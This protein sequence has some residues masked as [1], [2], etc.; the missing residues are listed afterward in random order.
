MVLL[1]KPGW[2]GASEVSPECTV[3]VFEGASNKIKGNV[4][5]GKSPDAS[6]YDPGT[7][8]VAVMNHA[9]GS[10]SLMDPVK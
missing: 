4:K 6:V 10:V 2:I 8:L 7:G 5:V 3:T 1:Q 9:D